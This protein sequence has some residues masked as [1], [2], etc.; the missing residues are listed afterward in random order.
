MIQQ[1]FLCILPKLESYEFR[2][3]TTKSRMRI[4]ITGK[5]A[6]LKE[7]GFLPFM[8][9]EDELAY[10][11]FG[12][13]DDIKWISSLSQMDSMYLAQY[14]DIY[15]RYQHLSS[16]KY[17]LDLI[18]STDKAVKRPVRE[19]KQSDEMYLSLVVKTIMQRIRTTSKLYIDEFPVVLFFKKGV[20]Y[21]KTYVPKIGDKKFYAEID[22]ETEI[23]DYYFGGVNISKDDFE[24][25][26]KGIS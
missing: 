15:S 11:L 8:I 18:R 6:W 22:L 5:V 4:E 24:K 14:T 16:N 17:R 7:L 19:E 2:D 9:A 20:P 21:T 12:N 25:I 26:L 23:G 3:S 1:K 10:E 13:A